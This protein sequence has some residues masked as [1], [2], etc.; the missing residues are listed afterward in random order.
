LPKNVR[1]AAGLK[2]GD[3]VAVEVTDGQIILRSPSAALRK[4]QELFANVPGNLVDELTAER[5]EEARRDLL[6]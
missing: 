2:P 6:D 1:D 3:K 5:R 4:L